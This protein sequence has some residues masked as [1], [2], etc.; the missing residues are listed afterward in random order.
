MKLGRYK[1]YKG[2]FYQVIGVALDK[3]IE[4]KVVLYHALY[5]C[6]E[7][8][9][10]YGPNP[11]FTRPYNEFFAEVEYDGHKMPRFEYVGK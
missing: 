8:L 4:N 2:K 9:D 10:E 7:L 11:I 3:A 1:H 6:P 5:N